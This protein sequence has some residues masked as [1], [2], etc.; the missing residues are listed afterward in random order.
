MLKSG[1]LN[2][3]SNYLIGRRWWSSEWV[4]GD[5][6]TS[7]PQHP[8][9]SHEPPHFILTAALSDGSS[10]RLTEEEADAQGLSC[11][12]RPCPGPTRDTSC[13]AQESP[14]PFHSLWGLKGVTQWDPKH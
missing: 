10:S 5:E 6:V 3:I 11:I 1:K 2:G 7:H 14:C 4:C 12:H 8:V 9:S 13:R